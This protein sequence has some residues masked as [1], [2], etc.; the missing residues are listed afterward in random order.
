ML[1][2]QLIFNSSSR[3]PTLASK[4][5]LLCISIIEPNMKLEDFCS[6]PTN[7]TKMVVGTG[8]FMEHLRCV[9]QD[10]HF[11]GNK[12]EASIAHYYANA[13]VLVC[14]N[15]CQGLEGIIQRASCCGTPVAARSHAMTDGLIIDHVTG[16]VSDDLCKA[17]D[18]CLALD[19]DMIEQIGHT[20]FAGQNN[21]ISQA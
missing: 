17:I 3:R 11:V 16:M 7:G 9:Y 4:P 10:V 20:F 12:P 15:G 19:R 2:D 13:D 1:V 8:S 6:F 21:L 5:I 18:G 14:P